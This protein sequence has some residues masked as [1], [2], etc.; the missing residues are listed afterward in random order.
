MRKLEICLECKQKQQKKG[1]HPK[2]SG[3]RSWWSELPDNLTIQVSGIR[4][5]SSRVEMAKG[6]KAR[7]MCIRDGPL[8][9]V[10]YMGNYLL[11]F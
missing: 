3:A 10:G 9:R 11:Y 2:Q 4:C 6:K 1:R 8:V 5:R 7:A